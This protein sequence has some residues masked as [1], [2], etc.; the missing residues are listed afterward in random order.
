M[1][2]QRILL[3][4]W[5]DSF[6]NYLNLAPSRI[7]SD[8]EEVGTGKLENSE[9]PNSSVFSSHLRVFINFINW[10]WRSDSYQKFAMSFA[11]CCMQCCCRETY[12]RL[13][14]Q[15]MLVPRGAW[16]EEPLS[17][18]QW[19]CDSCEGSATPLRP[20]SGSQLGWVKWGDSR[21]CF[22]LG[23]LLPVNLGCLSSR[24]ILA[25]VELFLSLHVPR[26]Q[27]SSSLT[28]WYVQ[29]TPLC[30][31]LSLLWTSVTPYNWAPTGWPVILYG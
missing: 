23:C 7:T 31:H 29:P 18:G 25:S 14:S 30:T 11:V 12:T 2:K 16:S 21:S 10:K 5:L 8:T 13:A 24:P 19:M 22:F 4:E 3:D 1:L 6:N 9:S 15:S 28:S 17:G 26:L 20:G 27:P